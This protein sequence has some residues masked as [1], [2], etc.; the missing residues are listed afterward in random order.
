ME[1]IRN[2]GQREVETKGIR[3]EVVMCYA[4]QKLWT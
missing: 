2:R 1:G 3:G 4:N